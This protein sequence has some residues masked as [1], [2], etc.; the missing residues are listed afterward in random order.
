MNYA[1]FCERGRWFVRNES[2]SELQPAAD[3]E[4]ALEFLKQMLRYE[5]GELGA[6]AAMKVK[7][8]VSGGPAL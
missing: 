2:V 7:V 4:Q 3:L 1:V 8:E 5:M 6:A